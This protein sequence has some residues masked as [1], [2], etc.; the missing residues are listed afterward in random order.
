MPLLGSRVGCSFHGHSTPEAALLL[1]WL[2]VATTSMDCRDLPGGV[3]NQKPWMW[4]LGGGRYKIC[5]FRFPPIQGYPT[6]GVVKYAVCRIKCFAPRRGYLTV[7][8]T[9]YAVF[10]NTCFLPEGALMVGVTKYA[11]FRNKC[12]LRQN[13]NKFKLLRNSWFILA[14]ALWPP[15]GSVTGTLVEWQSLKQ[16]LLFI[17]GSGV[18]VTKYAVFCNRGCLPT[19]FCDNLRCT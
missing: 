7:G 18:G 14:C 13:P 19:R 16:R 9:K 5:I 17:W 3:S 12:F 10:R 2:P 1:S 6:L 8:V 15:C 4:G 11:V